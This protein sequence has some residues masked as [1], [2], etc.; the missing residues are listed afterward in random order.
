KTGGRENA[1]MTI[2]DNIELVSKEDFSSI[3]LAIKLSSP[4]YLHSTTKL[5]DGRV[6]ILGGLETESDFVSEI[7][8]FDPI[9]HSISLSNASLNF[10][11]AY[12]TATLLP[13]GRVLIMGGYPQPNIEIYDP[14]NDDITAI[15][16]PIELRT[17]NHTAVLLEEQKILV[18]T[19]SG[20]LLIY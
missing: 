12:H 17:Y 9:S 10:P 2:V 8:I 1:T 11:R 4:R 13:D 7:E 16:T 20:A 5:L 15:T 18:S 3:P 6:L 14:F 19:I